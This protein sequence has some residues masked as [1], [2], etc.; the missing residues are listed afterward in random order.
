MRNRDCHLLRRLAAELCI[1]ASDI[2]HG[3]LGW[4]Q[5][6]EWT[7]LATTEF[8]L[9]GDEEARL[10]RTISP[11]C[12]R[13]SHS[14]LAKSQLGFLQHVVRPLFVELDIIDRNKMPMWVRF[15]LTT[16]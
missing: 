6:F 10:G 7:G 12:D 4:N 9:Q 11:L 16:R 3:A 5:H 8:Y 14:Q 1:R 2:G 13:D 15:H